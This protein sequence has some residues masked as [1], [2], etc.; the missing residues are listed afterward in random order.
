MAGVS[1][2]LWL[3]LLAPVAI[4]ALTFG[5]VSFLPKTYERFCALAS[6]SDAGR[7]RQL[8]R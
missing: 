6:Q 1:L 4:G 3:L 8:H 7:S 2:L 5:I